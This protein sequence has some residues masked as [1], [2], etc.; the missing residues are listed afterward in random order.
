MPDHSSC[1]NFCVGC[2]SRTGP[3]AF[4]RDERQN[5][6]GQNICWCG[7][8]QEAVRCQHDTQRRVDGKCPQSMLQRHQ[9]WQD[10]HPQVAATV[11]STEDE[12]PKTVIA[13]CH[14]SREPLFI[15]KGSRMMCHSCL[16]NIDASSLLSSDN[17]LSKLGCPTS[18]LYSASPLDTGC[19]F[20]LAFL[21]QL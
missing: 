13:W 18:F 9:D 21:A 2:R 15:F 17:A 8:C 19:I 12:D 4:L 7:F 5:S 6:D 10:P 16:I 3:F 11:H 20:P 1:Q 14:I